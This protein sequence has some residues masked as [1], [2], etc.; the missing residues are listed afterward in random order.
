MA[1]SN[2][3]SIY[4]LVVEEPNPSI[5]QSETIAEQPTHVTKEKLPQSTVTTILNIKINIFA[6]MA[7]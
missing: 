7:L 5:T 2:A 6:V 3:M 4:H 1:R